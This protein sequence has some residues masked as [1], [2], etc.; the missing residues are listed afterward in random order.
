MKCEDCSDKG[1]CMDEDFKRYSVG[2]IIVL[3]ALWLLFSSSLS[4][5][6]CPVWVAYPIV[7]VGTFLLYCMWREDAQYTHDY[8]CMVTQQLNKTTMPPN[9][10]LGALTE[11]KHFGEQSKK[12]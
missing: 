6:G 12:H 1:K 3:L 7:F 2:S 10:V 4:I 8:R 5:F 9:Q 11:A